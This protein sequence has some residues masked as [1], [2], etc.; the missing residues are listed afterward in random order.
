MKITESFFVQKS[1]FA[2]EINSSINGEKII[3]IFNLV[4]PN[5]DTSKNTYRR[6]SNNKLVEEKDFY[7]THLVNLNDI[8]NFNNEYIITLFTGNEMIFWK[9]KK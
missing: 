2:T 3:V 5:K 6:Y 1:I 9:I 4:N 8:L 7:N